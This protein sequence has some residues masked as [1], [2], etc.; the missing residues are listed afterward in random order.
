MNADNN[1]NFWEGSVPI[2]HFSPLINIKQRSNIMHP[3]KM[4]LPCRTQGTSSPT[5]KCQHQSLQTVYYD[6]FSPRVGLKA[7]IDWKKQKVNMDQTSVHATV[8]LHCTKTQSLQ[9]TAV[10]AQCTSH[11]FCQFSCTWRKTQKKNVQ[12]MI[13]VPTGWPFSTHHTCTYVWRK[14][15]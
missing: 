11:S 10:L 3:S 13:S 14:D 9:R 12:N 8:G 1:A 5:A 2:L 7:H 6:R 15:S 4:T